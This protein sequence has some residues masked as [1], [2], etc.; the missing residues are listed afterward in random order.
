[1][2]TT[3]FWPVKSNLKYTLDY[4]ENPDKTTAEKYLDNDLYA[5]IRYVE[6][7]DIIHS[8]ALSVTQLM[9]VTNSRLSV[10]SSFST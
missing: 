7:D 10:L 3:G 9:P 2:A 5:A 1:M 6:N 8:Y 4:A